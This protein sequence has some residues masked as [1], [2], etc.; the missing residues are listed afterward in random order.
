MA[1]DT[2]TRGAPRR[3]PLAPAL[4]NTA[5]LLS[6]QLSAMFEADWPCNLL[7]DV[8]TVLS[9]LSNKHKPVPSTHTTLTFV[10]FVMS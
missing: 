7:V 4:I 2:Q 6:W 5:D 8:L 1:N 9:H 3:A 10:C